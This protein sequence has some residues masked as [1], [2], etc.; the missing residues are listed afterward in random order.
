MLEHEEVDFTTRTQL[1]EIVRD[2][3]NR[4]TADTHWVYVRFRGASETE[5]A[6]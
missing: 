1:R 4:E 3:V 6:P 5:Q 2:L